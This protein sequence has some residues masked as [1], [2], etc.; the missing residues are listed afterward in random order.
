METEAKWIESIDR[1]LDR[2]SQDATTLREAVARTDALHESVKAN[3]AANNR[4][5]ESVSKIC[6]LLDNHSTE[7][8]RMAPVV[9]CYQREQILRAERSAFYSGVIRWAGVLSVFGTI[10][11][12]V[13][14][15]ASFLSKGA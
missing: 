2:I 4:L 11:A 8:S 1:R 7:I 10:T 13:V 15:V 9:E 12:A 6:Q 5:S 14:A 3:T